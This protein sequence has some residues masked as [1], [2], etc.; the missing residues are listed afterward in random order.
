MG[1][2][3]GGGYVKK[4]AVSPEQLQLLQQLISQ[5]S[6][7]IQSAAQGFNQFLPG[8]GGGQPIINQANRNFQQQTIPSI[9]NAFGNNTKGSSALNQALAAGAANLNTDLASQLS[10]LQLNAAQGIGNLGLGQAGLG[11][12]T[13]QFAYMQRQ[14]PFW[15]SALLG[16]IGLGG[17]LGGAALGRP[18]PLGRP[19]L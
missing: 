5:A 16:G 9:L 12:Q 15:Q 13:P 8:G 3:K 1:Q 7:Q 19:S 10:Q 14:Q 18:S 17:Q 4:E 2:S 11:S 6:P